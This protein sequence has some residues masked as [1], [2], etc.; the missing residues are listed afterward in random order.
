MA[1]R[2]AI[3]TLHST[4]EVYVRP[5]GYGASFKFAFGN[6]AKESLYTIKESFLVVT[7][8]YSTL[9]VYAEPVAFCLFRQ[10]LGVCLDTLVAFYAECDC[11]L[12]IR[13]HPNAILQGSYGKRIVTIVA[14]LNINA[15][16]QLCKPSALYIL[17]H[18]VYK[19][20]LCFGWHCTS[21]SK[22][23]DNSDSQFVHFM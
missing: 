7:Y 15:L 5:V 18:R 12:C 2:C 6:R 22:S 4:A 8:Y 11:V 14:C 21:Q 16:W 10:M 19:F 1:P 20:K 3:E 23:G 17:R 9:V 13:F